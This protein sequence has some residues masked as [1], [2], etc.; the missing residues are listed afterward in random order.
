MRGHIRKRG[1][2]WTIVFYVDV[3]GKKKQKWIG[4]FKTKFVGFLTLYLPNFCL[5][6]C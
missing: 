5:C 3:N 1:F 4:G 2:T 6:H